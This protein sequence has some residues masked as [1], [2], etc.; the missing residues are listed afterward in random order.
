MFKCILVALVVATA[1]ATAPVDLKTAEDFAILAKSGIS[2]VPAS[3]ITGDI[4]VSPIA[5][6][7]MT[8]FSEIMDQDSKTFSTASQITGKAYAAD[9][10]SP[11]PS[12]MT[13]AISDMETAYTDVAGRS[14]VDAAKQDVGAGLISGETFT[15][16]VY[17]WGS[18]VM[19]SSDIYIK[20]CSDDIFIF[21]A[22]GNVVAGSGTQVTLV[23]GG[24]RHGC[25]KPKASNIFWQ[26]AGSVDAGTTSHLE[27]VF[28]AKTKAVF[29]TKS[30]LNGRI[31][32]Q[33]ACTLDQTTV[34]QPAKI[35]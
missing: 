31:L 29:K 8:G 32:T 30:S 7:F 22:T 1:A 26:V 6:S 20:G 16:G 21:Q 19:F 2:T 4:G 18:D 9:Y 12:K 33:T 24:S 13:T 27:G 23:P 25:D 10:V 28:L 5:A 15:A 14:V 11:T 34:V 17:N 3:V 35:V